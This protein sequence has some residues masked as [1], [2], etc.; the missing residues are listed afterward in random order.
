[1]PVF[2]FDSNST[3]SSTTGVATVTFSSSNGVELNPI[4]TGSSVTVMPLAQTKTCDMCGADMPYSASTCPGCGQE[5]KA[6]A[7]EAAMVEIEI[8]GDDLAEADQ[9]EEATMP[10][11]WEGELA[12]EGMPSSD[13]RVLLS[14]EI[15]HRDLP[16][17]LMFQYVTDEGHKGAEACGKITNIWREARPDL[18]PGVTA[19]MGSGEFSDDLMGPTAA[20]SLE[21]EIVRHV[22]IDLSPSRQ[23]VLTQD[24]AEVT[25][26]N[27]DYEAY[28]NGEYYVGFAGEIMGATICPFSAFADAQLRSVS[29]DEALAASGQVRIARVPDSD[30]MIASAIVSFKVKKPALTASA[31]GLAPLR[32]PR[33]WFFTAEP[34]GKMPLTVT[35]DG[36]VYG[37]LATWD[38]CHHG[39]MNDCVLAKPSK[40]DYAFFHVGAIK[41]KEGDMVEVGR[42]V[43]GES[44]AAGHAS[45]DYGRSDAARFYD[46][47]ACVGAF[48]RAV[49]GKYGIW[50]SGVVRSD[51]PAERVRDMMANPPSGDWRSESG[52][53]ELIAA[54]SV[55]VPGFPVPRYEYALT[56]S[57]DEHEVKTLVATGYYELEKPSYSRAELRRRE[58]LINK[59]K[60]DLR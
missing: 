41:T 15:S 31:A 32:P 20:A 35:D 38:Q 21:N 27:F 43:V 4:T 2:E 7:E 39:F 47:T 14:G 22:S 11:T 60:E 17:T 6:V 48:V 50:L 53:L 37:H 44:T 55:P 42:V 45:I 56:A 18:G 54:L 59:A 16:L 23:I 10:S 28:M 29:P 49:D 9:V 30:A 33:D 51:C 13:G 26:E 19:I 3:S 12:F 40:T 25:E 52:W 46:K 58:M 1:M 24:L 8:N 5:M 34:A 36:R 57:V